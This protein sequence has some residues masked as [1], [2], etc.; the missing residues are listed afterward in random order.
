M[1]ETTNQIKKILNDVGIEDNIRAFIIQHPTQLIFE[2]SLQEILENYLF[3]KNIVLE[4]IES[5]RLDN[6]SFTL[7]NNL[8]SKLQAISQ[9]RGNVNH[10][11]QHVDLLLH[12]L[13]SSGILSNKIGKTDFQTERKKLS[14]QY[15]KYSDL[16]NNLEE[17]SKDLSFI[18]DS[19]KELSE[20]LLTANE[21]NSNLNQIL[22]DAIERDSEID[23]TLTNHETKLETIKGIQES[24]EE[25]KLSITTF[26]NNIEEYKNSIEKLSIELKSLLMKKEEIDSLIVSAN[27]ALKLG[28]TVGISSA[29]AS[30]YEK[31]NNGHMKYWWV[32][33]AIVFILCA[34]GL[35]IWIVSDVENSDKIAVVTGRIVAVGISIA[36]AVF[37]S[38]QY[39]KQKQIAEDYAYK[40]VLSK[41]IVAFTEEI[42]TSSDN[43]DQHIGNYLNKVLTEIHKDPLRERRS[44]RSTKGF[45]DKQ[46][47]QITEIIKSVK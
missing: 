21:S 23:K 40:A 18:H 38:N 41:S 47:E 32:V 5:G 12:D 45:T 46:V 14:E 31:A 2:L 39:I 4:E 8:L 10:V 16:I 30:Q 33:G 1:K 20:L 7:R 34:I 11:V 25:K 42:G 24:I 36:G 19:K 37:C 22:E 13:F 44:S 27:E 6:F 43:P 28:S 3:L 35:T 15:K 9:N 29:F 17:K 26:S